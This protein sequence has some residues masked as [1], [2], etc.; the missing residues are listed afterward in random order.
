MYF[1]SVSSHL[2]FLVENELY[3]NGHSMDINYL[4]ALVRKI[5]VSNVIPLI[6]NSVLLPYLEIWDC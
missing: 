6:P 2:K 4:E 1:T 5:T 3:I